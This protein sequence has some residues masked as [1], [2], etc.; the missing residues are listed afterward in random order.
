MPKISWNKAFIKILE[1]FFK[2][3]P[4][5][6]KRFYERVCLLRD[7]PQN[8]KLKNHKLEGTLKDFNAISIDQDNRLVFYADNDGTFVLFDIGPHD[9]VY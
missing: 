1:K 8:L 6:R 7:E 9:D 3:H 5:L 2:K 4:E